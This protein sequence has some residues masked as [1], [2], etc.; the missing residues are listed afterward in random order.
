MRKT[1]LSLSGHK[2]FTINSLVELRTRVKSL[3]ILEKRELSMKVQSVRKTSLPARHQA[4][5]GAT[6]C[7]AAPGQQDR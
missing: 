5:L 3:G 1:L 4:D 7:Q 2:E 6:A